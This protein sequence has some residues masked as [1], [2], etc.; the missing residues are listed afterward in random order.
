MNGSKEVTIED[1]IN[2]KDEMK[3]QILILTGILGM[4]Y[5]PHNFTLPEHIEIYDVNGSGKKINFNYSCRQPNC[6]VGKFNLDLMANRQQ[7]VHAQVSVCENCGEYKIH[8]LK[9]HTHSRSL[10]PGADEH[11]TYRL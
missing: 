9:V 7:P 11:N 10:G 3:G 2:H 8:E 4:H 1:L 5:T 6:E